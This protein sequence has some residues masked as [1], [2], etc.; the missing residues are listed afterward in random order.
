VSPVKQSD[1]NTK[2]LCSKAKRDCP[3]TGH[4]TESR[5]TRVSTTCRRLLGGGSKKAGMTPLSSV[6]FGQ[7]K[8]GSRLSG[9]ARDLGKRGATL[10]RCLCALICRDGSSSRIAPLLGS[11]PLPSGSRPDLREK[12][13]E[14]IR[15]ISAANGHR[16]RRRRGT[17]E[18]TVDS[19]RILDP[20]QAVYTGL[21]RSV[22]VGGH[23]QACARLHPSSARRGHSP[24]RSD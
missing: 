10:R 13:Q 3:Q 8:C 4:R 24:S 18:I 9:M 1:A 23:S 14:K 21:A 16:M 6:A 15:L 7:L 11:T 12:N 20:A 17:R 19:D 22:T 2:G 5:V